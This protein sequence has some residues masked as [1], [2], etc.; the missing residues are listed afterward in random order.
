LV[1]KNVTEV[2]TVFLLKPSVR[3]SSGGRGG[4]DRV[5]QYIHARFVARI[6]QRAAAQGLSELTIV[7]WSRVIW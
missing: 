5:Q 2:C 3:H 1:E 4:G 6:H 7:L